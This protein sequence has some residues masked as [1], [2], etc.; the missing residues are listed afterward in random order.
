MNQKLEKY[1]LMSFMEGPFVYKLGVNRNLCMETNAGQNPQ[2]DASICLFSIKYP[3]GAN[4]NSVSFPNFVCFLTLKIKICASQIFPLIFK[5]V[6][7][8]IKNPNLSG[9]KTTS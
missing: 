8:V 6:K 1:G 9:C 2:P 4:F 3:P 5:S 7:K